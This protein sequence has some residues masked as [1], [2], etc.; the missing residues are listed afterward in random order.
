MEKAT[1]SSPSAFTLIEAM[2]AIVVVGIAIAASLVVTTTTTTVNSSVSSTTTAVFLA[3]NI[4]EML[5]SVPYCNPQVP[6]AWK[7]RVVSATSLRS[8]QVDLDD[9]DDEVFGFDATDSNKS[10]VDA[11]FQPLSSMTT[12]SGAQ[13]FSDMSRY[14]QKITVTKLSATDFS[15]LADTA[16]DAG[17][18]R[19]RIDILY[20]PQG[21]TVSQPVYSL[22]IYRYRDLK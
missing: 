16:A 20:C 6:T 7:D 1:R 5:A 10:P 4:R 3:D 14:T 18:R 12:S 21:K 15:V 22:T 8:N 17:V 13:P 2:L 11:L 19:I 9:F